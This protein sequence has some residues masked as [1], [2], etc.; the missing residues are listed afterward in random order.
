MAS[1]VYSHETGMRE[2]GTKLVVKLDNSGK[3]Q[4]A[5]R[6]SLLRAF[7]FIAVC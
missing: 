5:G 7:V 2:Q 6:G 3:Q 1:Q 4:N